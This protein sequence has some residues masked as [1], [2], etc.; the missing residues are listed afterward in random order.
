M[1][2]KVNKL[3]QD[4]EKKHDMNKLKALYSKKGEKTVTEKIVTD[5]FDEYFKYLKKE[6][7]KAPQNESVV[8]ATVKKTSDDSWIITKITDAKTNGTSGSSGSSGEKSA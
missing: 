3:L 2:K 1:S 8:T 4:Y 5:V 7:K 6:L